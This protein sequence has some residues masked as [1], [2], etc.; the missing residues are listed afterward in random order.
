MYALN[1]IADD[2]IAME[3]AN[4]HLNSVGLHL[5]E[6]TTVDWYNVHLNSVV[7]N[8]SEYQSASTRNRKYNP[9]TNKYERT[10]S[11]AI[12]KE[13]DVIQREKEEE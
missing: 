11:A 9:S 10:A 3:G 8:F 1:L 4:V 13:I 12:L 2:A 6:Y 5:S 7:L